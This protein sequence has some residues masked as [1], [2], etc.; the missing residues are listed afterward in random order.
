[1][2]PIY[3]TNGNQCVANVSPTTTKAS[4][5]FVSASERIAP[6]EQTRQLALMYACFPAMSQNLV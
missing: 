2:T 1:L 5:S 4:R 6:M 3:D